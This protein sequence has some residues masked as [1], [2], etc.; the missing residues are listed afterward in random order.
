MLEN[1]SN[2]D[3]ELFPEDDQFIAVSNSEDEGEDDDKCPRIRFSWRKKESFWKPWNSSI[4]YKVLGKR[5]GFI[6][7]A[8][9]LYKFLQKKGSM[10]MIDMTNDFYLVKFIAKEDYTAALQG[11]PWMVA[12]HL[13]SVSKWQPHFDPYEDNVS[14][15]TA[16]IRFPVVPIEYYNPQA[17]MKL[18][19][20]VSK[21][22]FVDRT[23]IQAS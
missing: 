14:N 15:I 20:L 21:A 19:P 22:L 6:F 1:S 11:G 3:D 4:I 2:T 23:T 10:E 9:R 17:L 8:A 12:D 16:W 7:L 13:V 5:V 18:G